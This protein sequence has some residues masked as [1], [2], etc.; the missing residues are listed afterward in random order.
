MDSKDIFY[1]HFSRDCVLLNIKYLSNNL[2][3]NMIKKHI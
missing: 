2:I 1:K 3:T